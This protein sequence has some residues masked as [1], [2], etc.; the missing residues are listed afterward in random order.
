MRSERG[1]IADWLIKLL[2]GFVVV[3]VLLFDG[4]SILVNFFTLDNTADS[5]AIEIST[6]IAGGRQVP[7]H[8][9]EEEARELARAEGARL[10][11]FEIDNEDRVVRVRLRRRATTLVIGRIGW[12]SDW[13]RATADG[14]Q[15]TG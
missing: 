12:I 11:G 5:I 4:G 15:P 9:R 6:S 2:L 14:Q 8:I 1:V 3:G 13:T 7:D 10:V